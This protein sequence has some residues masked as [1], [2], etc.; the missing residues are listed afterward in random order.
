MAQS[1]REN[2]SSLFLD[3]S[4]L[5]ALFLGE[6]SV[7][8]VQ[9][10]MRN[11]RDQLSVSSVNLFEVSDTLQRRRSI[12]FVEVRRQI[13]VLVGTVVECIPPSAEIYWDASRIRA[14]YYHHKTC[15]I[16]LADSVLLAH[17]LDAKIVTTDRQI[18]K[19]AKAEG[20]EVV[21]LS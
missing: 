19:V 12:D 3:A 7:D 8:K 14:D 20:I 21:K 13:E 16:S 2:R 9:S 4:V 5:L 1:T 17:G 18:L 6:R 10:L 15:D 11:S